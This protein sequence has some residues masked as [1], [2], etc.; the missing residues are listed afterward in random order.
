MRVT[1]TGLEVAGAFKRAWSSRCEMEERGT[2][3]AETDGSGEEGVDAEERG[4]E[5]RRGRRRQ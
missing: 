1:G 5:A 3:G 2:T 4:A